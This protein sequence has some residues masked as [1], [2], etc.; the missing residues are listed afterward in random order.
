L[1]TRAFKNG[2]K[3]FIITVGSISEEKSREEKFKENTFEIKY[4][5]F[6]PYLREVNEN[7][8]EALKYVA[9]DTQK[10]MI[11]KYIEHYNSGD[12]EPHKES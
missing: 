2:D 8:K 1:N 9:N 6:A 11:E 3:K 4:G 7:L 5:E 12:I 10:E